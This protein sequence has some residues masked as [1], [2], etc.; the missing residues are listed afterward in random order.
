MKNTIDRAFLKNTLTI[1]LVFLFSLSYSQ[2]VPT[3]NVGAMF[4]VQTTDI[5]E[6]SGTAN[7]AIPLHNINVD[8]FNWPISLSYD[9][10]GIKIE[11][12]AGNV[13][14]SWSLSMIGV[15]NRIQYG[16]PDEFEQSLFYRSGYNYGSGYACT[17]VR[18][19][20][21]FGWF[22]NSTISNSAAVY[23][24][25]NSNTLNYNGTGYSSFNGAESF[26][27]DLIVPDIFRYILPNGKKG[28][29]M[30]KDKTTIVKS[31]NDRV[32][33]SFDANNSITSFIITDDLGNSYL[34]DVV[35]QLTT[36]GYFYKTTWG[37]AGA[38]IPISPA[39]TDL[40][41]NPPTILNPLAV[42]CP[43]CNDWDCSSPGFMNL[44]SKPTSTSWF[45]SKIITAKN[46]LITFTYED[47]QHIRLSNISTSYN[48]PSA[49]SFKYN[50]YNSLN[51]FTSKRL[52]KIEEPS[53]YVN[54][55]YQP[56]AREDVSYSNPASPYYTSGLKAV[57]SIKVFNKNNTIIKKIDF[58]TSYKTSIGINN[59]PVNKQYLYKRLWL[60]KVTINNNEI[61]QFAYNTSDLPNR[62]SFEQDYWGYYNGNQSDSNGKT[63][64]PDLWFYPTDNK[65]YNR[66]TNFSIFK[67]TTFNGL[68][69]KLSTDSDFN[70]FYGNLSNFLSDRDINES[71]L[72]AGVLTK[73][74][75]PTKGY[76]Q[77]SYESNDFLFEN[78]L[79]KGYGLRIN[80]IENFDFDNTLIS[81]AT[82]DYK[83]I[84]GTSSGV[85]T[86]LPIFGKIAYKNESTNTFGY[87]FNSNS[88]SDDMQLFYSRVQKQLLNNGKV[89]SEY[90]IPYG[91]E[92][93]NAL[94]FNN[95][96]LY[97]KNYINSYFKITCWNSNCN[98]QNTIE[99]P[100][101]SFTRNCGNL[102]GKKIKEY[103]YDNNN[104]LLSLVENTYDF[105]N[106]S[107]KFMYFLGTTS[108]STVGYGRYHNV[109]SYVFADL[110]LGNS[111]TTQYLN[112]N[113]QLI[114]ETKFTYDGSLVVA[115]EKNNS[116]G[117]L[118]K[119]EIK[120]PKSL[121]DAIST[122]FNI[123]T[124]MVLMNFL[125]Y[126]IEVVKKINGQVVFAKLNNYDAYPTI[127]QSGFFPFGLLLKK[128]EMVLDVNKP[129]SD[130]VPTTKDHTFD[131]ND[132]G[133]LIKDSRYRKV[134]DYNKY[135]DKGN[136]LETS[137]PNG[138]NNVYVY[139]YNKTLPIA[140]IDN[141]LY[142]SIPQATITNL[143]ALSNSDND[144]CNNSSCKEQLLRVAL[145]NLR[146]TFPLAMITTYT[147]DP[148]VGVT[149]VTDSRGD[150][151]YYSY[152]EFQR[153]K[154]VRDNDGNIISNNEYHYKN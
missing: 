124:S 4:K 5:N 108:N 91:M 18:I 139:G 65:S 31:S 102:F 42:D 37:H 43:E 49:I 121:M 55:I 83:Q 125:N 29:F 131:S 140:K 30:L 98:I 73:I 41:W 104:S 24:D 107:N 51:G 74:I 78:E 149:S 111:K 85:I 16:L 9:S 44:Y 129:I 62:L 144:N 14:T 45:L 39:P 132:L 53:G 99:Y 103:I 79:K 27:A 93:E 118:I 145:N 19:L 54:I 100:T 76:E 113:Q 72:K 109:M 90:F 10:R 52:I 117:Q 61:Y 136:I 152:D 38:Q 128:N 13:G 130:F 63:L 81:S 154:E 69:K 12:E 58:T 150:C 11:E 68:E 15:I 120:Y 80:K 2:I 25:A 135:D 48:D 94:S 151:V 116:K 122:T 23:L 82:Y 101:T 141:I 36:P 87:T 86:N 148:I 3:P 6:S 119:E 60:D 64:L 97:K 50:M 46:K 110:L 32:L 70:N 89:I 35:E 75:Y 115:I 138:I 88:F 26:P 134:L 7:V 34:F 96:F 106:D 123:Y 105:R 147:Y 59:A 47:E 143:Q 28:S 56:Y 67:R 142:S 127:N 20:D 71:T 8:D 114:D 146:T 133:K 112:T 137:K 40:V 153:L 92:T 66:P 95:S 57:N 77:L 1:F 17:S 21:N 22:Q 84:D 126:P 33:A